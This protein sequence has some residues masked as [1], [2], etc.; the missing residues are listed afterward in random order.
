M[1]SIFFIISLKNLSQ[2]Y[3]RAFK[4]L[5]YTMDGEYLIA[6]G[7]SKYI[8]IYNIKEEMLVKRFEISQNKSFDGIDVRINYLWQLIYF[9]CK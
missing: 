1:K 8:C 6:G 5:C 2:Y 3:F 4:S 7:K 9:T